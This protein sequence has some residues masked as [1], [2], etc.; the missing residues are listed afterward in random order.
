MLLQ[1]SS[2]AKLS[3]SLMENFS[4]TDAKEYFLNGISAIYYAKRNNA[5]Y[6]DK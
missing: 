5:K 4:N 2:N 1:R 3:V 6:Y